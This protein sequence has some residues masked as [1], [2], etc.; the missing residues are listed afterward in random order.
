MDFKKTKIEKLEFLK[1]RGKKI[2]G[3]QESRGNREDKKQ[4][5]YQQR[6]F[7]KTGQVPTE[8]TTRKPNPMKYFQ[9]NTQTQNSLVNCLTLTL[10]LKLGE[11]EETER[12]AAEAAATE[13]AKTLDFFFGMVICLGFK[14]LVIGFLE[15]RLRCRWRLKRSEICDEHE[16]SGG[17]YRR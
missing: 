14:N 16:A 5:L 15:R 6:N 10:E 13:A 3:L 12:A 4:N 17:I 9:E 8:K 7:K 1:K 2:F 11:E